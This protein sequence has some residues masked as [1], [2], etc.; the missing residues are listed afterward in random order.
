MFPPANAKPKTNIF[1]SISTRGLA[2]SVE[3]LNSFLA[4]PAGDLWPKKGRPI[5]WLVRSLKG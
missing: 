1:F 5:Y 4:L 2:E 3:G